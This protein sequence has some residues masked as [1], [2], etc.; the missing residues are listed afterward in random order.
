MTLLA[1]LAKLESRRGP[2]VDATARNAAAFLHR[3]EALGARVEAGGDFAHRPE[4][5]PA[6][7]LVRALL[8]ATAA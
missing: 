3:L 1:R 8:R 7:N 5:S 6:E 2:G 4:A